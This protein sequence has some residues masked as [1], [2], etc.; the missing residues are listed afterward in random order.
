M[1]NSRGFPTILIHS[2]CYIFMHSVTPIHLCVCRLI[3]G[4]GET[5]LPDLD[6]T[7]DLGHLPFKPRNQ[8]SCTLR[9]VIQSVLML[10]HVD[11]AKG[12]VPL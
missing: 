4:A 1:Y 7:W 11:P 5:G 8:E 10:V 6:E 9:A 3:G 12:L 2:E